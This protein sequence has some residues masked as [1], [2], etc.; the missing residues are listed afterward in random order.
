M[1][2]F[3][4]QVIEGILTLLQT[5]G[6]AALCKTSTRFPTSLCRRLTVRVSRPRSAAGRLEAGVG[7]RCG[8]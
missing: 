4:N 8:I 7:R 3:Y 1:R 6:V 5:D 2:R